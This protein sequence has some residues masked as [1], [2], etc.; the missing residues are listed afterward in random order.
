MTWS[1]RIKSMHHCIMQAYAQ[2]V[3][4]HDSAYFRHKHAEAVAM[5]PQTRL[6]LKASSAT[7]LQGHVRQCHGSPLIVQAAAEA[8]A[9][10]KGTL[11]ASAGWA[12]ATGTYVGCM[13]T[14]Y[15][16]QCFWQV[17]LPEMSPSMLKDVASK[18]IVCRPARS[19][20]LPGALLRHGYGMGSTAAVMTGVGAPYQGGRLAYT[21]DLQGPCNG[22]DT[23]CSSSL[24]AAHNALQGMIRPQ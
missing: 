18:P 15:G 14:D 10:S 17:P 2:G 20:T 12:G 5:D 22:I 8:F 11:E 6:L 23:A 19:G 4:A 16:A 21:F 7:D 24:V 3:D 13:F 1:A 9:V